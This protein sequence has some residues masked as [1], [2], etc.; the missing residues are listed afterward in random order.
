MVK[1]PFKFLDSYTSD[2]KDIFF[3]REKEVEELYYKIFDGDLL[4]VYGSSGTGKTSLIQCGLAGKFEDADWMPVIV[5]RAGNINES[6]KRTLRHIAIT[7]LKE[8]NTLAQDIK[9]V[10]LD[11]FKPVYLLFDQFEELFI[12]GDD[13][14]I[15]EFVES[16]KNCLDAKISCKFIFVIRGEYLEH[17]SR[18]ED[19]IPEFF[20]NRMR[21]ERMTRRNAERVIT[22]PCRLFDIEVSEGFPAKV[23]ERLG[24]DKTASIELTYL[25][26]YLDK[27]YKR[28]M[29]KDPAHIVF[30]DSLLEESGRIDDV[31]SEFL[32]EQVAKTDDPEE[33][34]TIL[35][36]FVSNEGTKKQMSVSDVSDFSKTLG[37][38]LP[39]EVIEKYLRQFVDLRILKDKDD[40]N[41]YELRHDAL[42]AKIFEQ[43]SYSEKEMLEVR[44]FII[45]RYNDYT[46][47]GTYLQQSDIQYIL[48]YENKMFLN[49]EQKAF[50]E[51]S[52]RSARSKKNRRR[53]IFIAG[54]TVLLVT[55]AGFS[56]FAMKQRDEALVQKRI[57]EQKTTEALN[58]KE[59][60]EKAK[61]LSLKASKQA[62]DA[63]S[64]AELQSNIAVEQKK[65]AQQQALKAQ[66]QSEIATEQKSIAEEQT[67]KA[68]E[69]KDKADAEKDKAEKA[70]TEANR[71]R[72]LALSQNVAFKSQQ[73]KNEPQLAALLSSEAYNLAQENG[74]NVQDAQLYA[75]LYQS[76]KNFDPPSY[77]NTIQGPASILAMSSSPTGNA[78]VI[79]ANGE[80]AYYKANTATPAKMIS[81]KGAAINTAYIS[82]DGKYALTAYEDNSAKIWNLA[83]GVAAPVLKGHTGLIRAADFSADGS[84]VA[85][86]GRDSTVIV[87]DNNQMTKKIKYPSRVKSIALSNNKKKILVGCEDGIVYE[88]EMGSSDRG[89]ITSYQGA[90]VQ[91]VLYSSN[92]K[93]IVTSASNGEISIFDASGKLVK[94]IAGNSS[95]DHVVANDGS[96]LLAVAAANRKV[97][98]YNLNNLSQKPIEFSDINSFIRG[99]TLSPDG[100]VSVGMANNSIRQYSVKTP[101]IQSMLA[102][103]IKRN[104]SAEEWN[105][106]IGKDVPYRKINTALP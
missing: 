77:P 81:L 42:A 10:Y 30:N 53:N 21:I 7:P 59:L 104:M 24:H 40:N 92:D 79:Y 38:K 29:T 34:L 4:I 35:K 26:V 41:K 47:R 33:A 84:T 65:L 90:R 76:L 75:S 32:D 43:I 45:N 63:K 88:N 25:Q 48:P 68:K 2:D 11:Y 56:I 64:Y 71:L 57:A 20:N 82:D 100:L 23:L 98:I 93:Y 27:L 72:L 87:W 22:E 16:L 67:A 55:L 73:L 52:I 14:E 83:S 37:K 70:Q 62:L 18:F 36:S 51:E 74:G 6:L 1:T 9:S 13:A 12:F 5:R 58:Q 103:Y 106:Y 78:M 86:G 8:K 66:E 61:D 102:G 85:T 17:I 3:G 46:K 39:E 28:A 94:N 44:Q 69:E 80:L 96:G 99:I 19:K 54:A 101:V 89:I 105:T 60:A 50:V 97:Y 91:N 95:I 31:L 15:E 49:D